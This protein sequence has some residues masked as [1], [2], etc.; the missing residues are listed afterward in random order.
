MVAIKNTY[1]L[2]IKWI[3][4]EVNWRSML[5]FPFLITFFSI[6]FF[7][8]F[9]CHGWQNYFLIKNLI[10]RKAQNLSQKIFFLSHLLLSILY[11]FPF[12]MAACCCYGKMLYIISFLFKDEYLM[13]YFFERGGF[14]FFLDKGQNTVQSLI[15]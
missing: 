12:V 9:L 2:D 10:K 13:P 1:L 8:F 4:V 11:L 14:S 5:L 3:K 6:H 15:T 7:F